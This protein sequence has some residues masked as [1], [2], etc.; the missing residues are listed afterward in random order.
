MA[1]EASQPLVEEELQ[2][3]SCKDDDIQEQS[4]R[5]RIGVAYPRKRLLTSD[6]PEGRR[7]R[8]KPLQKMPHESACAS[9]A[10]ARV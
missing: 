5:G 3:S 6:S 7:A 4:A 9:L 8:V 2:G 10:P 1:L